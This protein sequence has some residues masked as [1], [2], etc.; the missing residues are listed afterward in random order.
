MAGCKCL[1]YKIYEEVSMQ[2]FEDSIFSSKTAEIGGRT[3][4][5]EV[6]EQTRGVRSKKNPVNPST[7]RASVG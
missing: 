7:N 4:A 2:V 6:Y 3:E 1:M 5:A